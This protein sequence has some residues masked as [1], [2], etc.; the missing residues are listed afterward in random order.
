M[1]TGILWGFYILPTIF[2]IAL[3]LWYAFIFGPKQD[4][5]MEERRER[6]IREREA[7]AAGKAAKPE[8]AGKE[9]EA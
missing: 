7:R 2:T 5:E 4:R 6:L 3:M 9:D 1:P 8:N